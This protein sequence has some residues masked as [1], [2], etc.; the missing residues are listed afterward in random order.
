MPYSER[1]VH[2]R[3]TIVFLADSLFQHDELLVLLQ[4]H[5]CPL[6]LK[7]LSERPLFPLTLRSTR[8]VFLLL[9][10]FSAELTT[11]AEV[12]L[13]M[14]IKVVSGDPD[15]ATEVRPQWMRVLAMEIIRG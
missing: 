3:L 7:S 4:H 8:V 10:Q 2:Q 5:L 6:L 12:F 15:A 14:L 1:F 11:E 9:K 13:M